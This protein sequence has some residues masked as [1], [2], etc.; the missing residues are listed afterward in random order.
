MQQLLL[1][2]FVAI[3]SGCGGLEVQIDRSA[4]P[5]L[6]LDVEPRRHH[7]RRRR[8]RGV[9]TDQDSMRSHT[10]IIIIRD[11]IRCYFVI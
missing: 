6:A 7:G 11:A 10:N 2:I 9:E 3:T 8:D 4:G 1:I 5:R